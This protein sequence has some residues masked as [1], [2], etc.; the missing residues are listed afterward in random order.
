MQR[1]FNASLLLFHFHFGRGA[2]LDHSNA[3]GQLGHALLQFLAVIVGS[4]FFHLLAD[5][6]HTGLDLG[7][8]ASAVDDSGIFLAHFNA[9][10]LAQHFQR[11]FF[12]SQANFFGNHGAAGQDGD[13]LQHGFAT[14]TKARGFNGNHFQNAADGVDHQSRQ[15]FAFNVFGD[16]QQRTAGLGHL[17]QNRQQVADI[18]DFLVEQQ[19]EGIVQSGNLLVLIVDEVRGQVAAVELHAFNHVQLVVQALAVFNGN[20]A[21][22]AHFFH[23]IGDDV[24]DVGI[25]VG[26]DGAYLSDFLSGSARL[27]DLGDFTHQRGN[28]FVD[29]AL[30]IHRVHAGGNVFHTFQHD[31]LSQHGG[32]GGA[33]AGNVGSLGSDFFHHLRAHVLELIFQLD[34]LGDGY[35]VL[36]DGR[37]AEGAVQHHVAAFRAQSHFNGISQDVDAGYHL[38]ASGITKLYVFSSH[39]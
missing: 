12:Q 32:G 6:A 16:D 14:I 37:S 2:N 5:L 9:L 25:G 33:V 7:S 34:F 39:S 30:Q 26:G 11:S 27:G 18:G 29:A 19:D 23:G 35:A 13:I 3:A 36:G 15:R 4:G 22:L 17:L 21:F 28:G 24:A 20:H 10:G 38:G 31:G 8:L 1:V